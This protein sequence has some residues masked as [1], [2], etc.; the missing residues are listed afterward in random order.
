M[1]PK[2]EPKYRAEGG[3]I[4]NRAS[5]EQIPD[6]EPVFIFRAR[7]VYAL[8]ALREYRGWISDAH[9]R[10]AVTGRIA[11]FRAFA[12]AHPERMKEP[13]TAREAERPAD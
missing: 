13:D 7:D 6:D 9:H 8:H 4:F 2:Q 1:D 12:E 10:A 11:D 3:R 5:G